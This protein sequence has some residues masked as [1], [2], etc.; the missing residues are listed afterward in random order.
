M[1]SASTVG[2][3]VTPESMSEAHDCT[4]LNEN[5]GEPLHHCSMTATV[6]KA[7]AYG[8]SLYCWPESDIGV[9]V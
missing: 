6:R 8:F 2:Q 1:A 4:H 5:V 7:G 3:T 9:Y